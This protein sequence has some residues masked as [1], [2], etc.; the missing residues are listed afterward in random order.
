MTLT[1]SLTVLRARWISAALVFCAL[2]AVVAFKTFTEQRR[3]TADASVLIDAQTPDPVAGVTLQ[4]MMSPNYMLTQVDV[5]RSLRVAGKVVKELNLPSDAELQRQWREATGGARNMELWL[6]ERLQ[7]SL[8]VRPSRGS[9]VINVSYTAADPKLA[10]AVANAFVT[11]YVETTLELRIEPARQYNKFFEVHAR[12]LRAQLEEA[13]AKLSS[14]QRSQGIIETDE[15]LDIE[16]ARLAALSAELV[17]MQSLAVESGSRQGAARETPDQI[18]E[19]LAS[20]VIGSLTSE[21]SKQE[22]RLEELNSRLGEQHPQVLELQ[23]NIDKL[24]KRIDIETKRVS[25]SV[26]VANS[27]NRTRLASL[28]ASLEAQ[29]AKVLEMKSR[30]DGAEVLQQDVANAQ[31]AYDAV[32][33]RVSQTSLEG[34]T[35]QSNASVLELA[36]PPAIA[37]S[38]RVRTNLILGG[39]LSIALA[40]GTVA[41]REHRDARLR[42]SDDVPA[43]IGQQVIAMIPEFKRNGRPLL[44]SVKRLGL[45]GAKAGSNAAS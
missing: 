44:M 20:G 45:S 30:R 23:A 40:L 42:L 11:G 24:R 15:K 1:R 10:A 3:Y 7:Q 29:R 2:M 35:A 6:A 9:N 32:L 39:L 26:S 16:N 38:P 4:G 22:A 8:D 21:L 31:R 18:Q 14:Y 43:L 12:Q 25:A 37:S 19:V 17:A 36:T 28:R 5:I 13:K 41:V 34:Q 33:A 27:V